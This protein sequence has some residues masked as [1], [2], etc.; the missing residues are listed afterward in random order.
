VHRLCLD[1]R[2]PPA[3]PLEHRHRERTRRDGSQREARA[4]ERAAGV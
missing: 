3:S 4:D 2:E 1:R